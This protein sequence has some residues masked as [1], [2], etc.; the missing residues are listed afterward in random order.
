MTVFDKFS[1]ISGLKL[2][3]NKTFLKYIGK[4]E[5]ATIDI[6]PELGIERTLDPI[7][8]LGIK[9]DSDKNNQKKLNYPDKLPAIRSAL[10]PWLSQ[11]LTP[12]GKIAVINCKAL[13]KMVYLWSCLPAPDAEFIKKIERLITKFIIITP[14]FMHGPICSTPVK[15]R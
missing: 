12:F 5:K 6:N 14:F 13:S 2:N 15:I 11:G 7:T 10:S 9:I 1:R 3:K 4:N 8:I